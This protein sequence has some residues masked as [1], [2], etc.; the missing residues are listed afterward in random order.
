MKL[1][2]IFAF[3]LGITMFPTACADVQTYETDLGDVSIDV[4]HTLYP[5]DFSSGTTLNLAKPGTQKPLFVILLQDT[6]GE[7]LENHAAGMVGED[8]TYTEMTTDDGHRMLFYT[9]DAGQN[10]KGKMIYRYYAFIDH[11]TDKEVVIEIFGYSETTLDGEVIA[12][13][14]EDVFQNICRSFAFVS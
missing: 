4:L 5:N 9:I 6:W 2:W 11:L 8:K 12:V 13:F 14:D 7:D 1:E 10:R 3:V